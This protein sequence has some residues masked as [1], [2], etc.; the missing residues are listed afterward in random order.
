M[1][2]GWGSPRE[3]TQET[4]YRVML[5]E[6]GLSPDAS[7]EEIEA[8]IA[9]EL[10]VGKKMMADERL[11]FNMKGPVGKESY[12]A[13]MAGRGLSYTIFDSDRRAIE[14]GDKE[15]S[16]YTRFAAN[17]AELIMRYLKVNE[18]FN[19][20]AAQTDKYEKFGNRLER[21]LGTHQTIVESFLAK[22]L[23]KIEGPEKK[24]E[25]VKSVGEGFGETKGIRVE[26]T[27][28]GEEES[29]SVIYE[30]NGQKETLE[31]GEDLLKEI[32]EERKKFEE[33]VG[34]NHSI[35]KTTERS[36]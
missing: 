23:E 13:F 4:A 32:I 6:K 28:K 30:I 35:V 8:V 5:A 34:K 11:D 20:L 24:A 18:N 19:R 22:I 1:S 33:A 3:R 21:Y 2:L 17:I 27:K 29:I 31:I 26:I 16:T 10:K 14:T 15:S 7:L 25:F 12:D 9:Q 36:K